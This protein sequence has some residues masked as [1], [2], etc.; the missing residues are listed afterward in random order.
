MAEGCGKNMI[1]C[2][3]SR[4]AVSSLAA[5]AWQ[6]CLQFIFSPPTEQYPKDHGVHV[7]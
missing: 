5:F 3:G 4:E 6:F 2:D 1:K 7:V